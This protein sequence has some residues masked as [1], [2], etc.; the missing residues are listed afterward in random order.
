MTEIALPSAGQALLPVLPLPA[1]VVF[2]GPAAPLEVTEAPG[3][4]AVE[5]ATS[6][7]SPL[8]LFLYHEERDLD[9]IEQI[10]VSARIM[11]LV[12]LPTGGM[13]LVVQGITRVRRLSVVER[14]PVARL[15]VEQIEAPQVPLQSNPL[16]DAILNTFNEVV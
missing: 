15:L 1:V 6:R 7:N 14:E 10:G 8:A 4:A 3:I 13:R 11:H 9:H 16:R 12:R 5:D 2:P